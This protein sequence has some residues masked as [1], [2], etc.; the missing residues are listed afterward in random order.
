MIHR[1]SI[2]FKQLF[3]KLPENIQTEAIERFKLLQENP[4]NPILHFKEFRATG[5]G[6][7]NEGSF[8]VR[9]NSN[10]RALG[11]EIA[12]KP[13]VIVWWFIGDH[14]AYMK[15]AEKGRYTKKKV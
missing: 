7:H 6:I 9:V 5:G 3:T 12:T 15:V 13:T 11:T 8:S 14:S 2:G 1:R 4:A 10:Y